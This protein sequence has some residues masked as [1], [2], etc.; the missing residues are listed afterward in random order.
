MTKCIYC[1]KKVEE[2][3]E[4][5]CASCSH[6]AFESQSDHAREAAAREEEERGMSTLLEENADLTEQDRA[7]VK[8]K[9]IVFSYVGMGGW[10]CGACGTVRVKDVGRQASQVGR[11]GVLKALLAPCEKC[12][13]TS[14]LKWREKVE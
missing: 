14:G 4:K 5:L 3:G 2:K 8:K 6:A 9:L 7:L 11:T 13:A 10:L 12:G 1:G